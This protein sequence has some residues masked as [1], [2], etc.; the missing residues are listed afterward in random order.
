MAMHPAV[1]LREKAAET[2]YGKQMESLGY[3]PV[4]IGDRVGGTTQGVLAAGVGAT[5][6]PA[7][8]TIRLL[9]PGVRWRSVG[10][11]PRRALL[12]NVVTDLMGDHQ[13]DQRPR[14]L[15]EDVP[16]RLHVAE[17]ERQTD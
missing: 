3:A 11:R 5:E 6:P 13:G 17:I 12:L 14:V 7:R 9:F 10:P 8:V 15:S 2:R 4:Q 1:A 16:E